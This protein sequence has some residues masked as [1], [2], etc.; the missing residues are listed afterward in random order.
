[1]STAVAR[2]GVSALDGGEKALLMENPAKSEPSK[3]LLAGV[4][5]IVQWRLMLLHHL[6]AADNVDAVGQGAEVAEHA[7]AYHVVDGSIALG[8]GIDFVDA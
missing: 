2:A 1:M 3:A 6:F 8:L 5:V 4:L 7:L